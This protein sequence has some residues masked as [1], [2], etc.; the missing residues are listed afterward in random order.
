VQQACEYLVQEYTAGDEI[1]PFG[2]SRGPYTVRSLAGMVRKCGI[3]RRQEAGRVREACA[4]YMNRRVK[5]WQEA[6]ERFRRDYSDLD[7]ERPPERAERRRLRSWAFGTPWGR[8]AFPSAWRV[9]VQSLLQLP[10]HRP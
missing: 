1:F 9:A 10:R 6:A 5:P 2:C 4:V 3:L 8:W 7:A